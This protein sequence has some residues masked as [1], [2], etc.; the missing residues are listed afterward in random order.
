METIAEIYDDFDYIAIN[1]GYTSRLIHNIKNILEYYD[2]S[3]Y[4]DIIYLNDFVYEFNEHSSYHKNSFSFENLPC[5]YKILNKRK[6]M[7]NG[8]Y[9]NVLFYYT[10]DAIDLHE[11]FKSINNTNILLKSNSSSISKVFVFCEA[12]IEN[13][14]CGCLGF[15]TLYM[16]KIVKIDDKKVLILE[17]DTESG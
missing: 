2:S 13:G 7:D 11:K 5:S 14:H 16:I 3:E 12:L 8:I 4:M 15:G 10:D 6:F 1:C 9:N 17:F